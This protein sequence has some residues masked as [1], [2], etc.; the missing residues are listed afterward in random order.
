MAK[1]RRRRAMTEPSERAVTK[2]LRA[3]LEA[4][5]KEIAEAVSEAGRLGEL[6]K[7]TV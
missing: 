5:G 2:E 1:S 7:E 6:L 4:S 3:S